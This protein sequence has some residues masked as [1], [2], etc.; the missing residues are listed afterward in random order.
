MSDACDEFLRRRGQSVNGFRG[1][2]ITGQRTKP[3]PAD[4]RELRKSVESSAREIER[5][6]SGN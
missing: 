5:G 2:G 3:K 4:E 1:M 6:G